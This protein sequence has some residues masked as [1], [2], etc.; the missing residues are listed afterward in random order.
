MLQR[1]DVPDIFLERSPA[2]FDFDLLKAL[3]NWASTLETERLIHC[4]RSEYDWKEAYTGISS[5]YCPPH[6]SQ[7]EQSAALAAISVSAML[8]AEAAR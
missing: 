4:G 1:T 8:T 7:I 5:L 6:S 3:F 2:D